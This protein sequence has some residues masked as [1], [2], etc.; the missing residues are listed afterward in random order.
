LAQFG[1]RTL[2]RRRRAPCVWWR[3]MRETAAAAERGTPSAEIALCARAGLGVK[4]LAG[5]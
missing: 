1:L 4:R 2:R 5:G 3:A